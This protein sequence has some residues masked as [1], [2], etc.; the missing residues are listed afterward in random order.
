MGVSP[1]E[2]FECEYEPVDTLPNGGYH[3]SEE[4]VEVLIE[5]DKLNEIN[6][7]KVQAYCQALLDTQEDKK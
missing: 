2:L 1:L 3:G 4:N 5:F 7:A 6:K